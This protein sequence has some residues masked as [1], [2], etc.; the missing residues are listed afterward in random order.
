[1]IAGNGKNKYLSI[2]FIGVKVEGLSFIFLLGQLLIKPKTKEIKAN[3]G[4]PMKHSELEANT[5]S[6]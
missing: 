6:Q 1:M 4:N 5:C 2:Y 3:A